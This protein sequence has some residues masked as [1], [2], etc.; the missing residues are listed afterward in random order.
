MCSLC[1]DTQEVIVKPSVCGW[2]YLSGRTYRT[3]AGATYTFTEG[4]ED[5]LVCL[6]PECHPSHWQDITYH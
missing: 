6:C 1:N 3:P 5:L 4:K 2:I